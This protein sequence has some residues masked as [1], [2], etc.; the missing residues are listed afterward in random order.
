[1]NQEDYIDKL[2]EALQICE[3]HFQRMDYALS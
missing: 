3:I 1:M 2:K